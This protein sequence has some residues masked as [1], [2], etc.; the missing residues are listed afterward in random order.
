MFGCGCGCLGF[1]DKCG[2]V[3]WGCFCVWGVFWGLFVVGCGGFDVGFWLL[4][5]VLML[6]VGFCV[7]IKDNCEEESQ[8]LFFFRFS[9]IRNSV[10]AWVRIFMRYERIC[11]SESFWCGCRDLNPGRQRGR[12]MS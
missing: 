6:V 2:G 5:C 8:V 11:K 1:F 10:G 9:S 7:N 3:F 12:L 4:G